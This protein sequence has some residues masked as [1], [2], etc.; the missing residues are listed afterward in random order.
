M[1]AKQPILVGNASKKNS[2]LCN[3]SQKANFLYNAG[4]KTDFSYRQGTFRR[5]RRDV[6]VDVDVDFASLSPSPKMVSLFFK[7]LCLSEGQ[8]KHSRSPLMAT[9][10]PGP[11]LVLDVAIALAEAGTNHFFAVSGRTDL[12]TQVHPAKFDAEVD[13]EAHFTPAP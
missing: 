4:K 6:E 13:F 2:F 7:M 10:G 5:W 11:N 9:L 8:A 12:R 1:R 3:A